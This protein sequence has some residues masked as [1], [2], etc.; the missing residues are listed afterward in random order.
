VETA[1]G[2]KAFADLT[3]S[4]VEAQVIAAV[5]LGRSAGDT[6]ASYQQVAERW[7]MLLR[8]MKAENAETV[9]GLPAS[10]VISWA[11]HLGMFDEP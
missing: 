9:G 5:M 3:Q 8:D 11:R 1:D 10:L 6:G 4:D 2:S 7:R